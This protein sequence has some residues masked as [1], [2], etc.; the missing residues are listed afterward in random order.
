MWL[1]WVITILNALLSQKDFVNVYRV[2]I[3]VAQIGVLEVLAAFSLV[4]TLVKGSEYAAKYPT[5]RTSPTLVLVMVLYGLGFLS[6]V[7]GAFLNG[8]GPKDMLVG[9]REFTMYPIA[10]FIGYRLLA[11]PQSNLKFIKAML[12]GGVI[13]STM[14]VINFGSNA[15]TAGRREAFDVLR[16]VQYVSNYCAIA[17]LFLFF[18]TVAGL[19]PMRYWWAV[20]IGCFCFVGALSNFSRTIILTLIF[21]AI[22]M[23]A[24]LPRQKIGGIVLRS[25]V[26]APILFGALYL[27]IYLP[28]Q[29]KVRDI[30]ELIKQKL[31]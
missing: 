14:M 19:K 10:M 26:L 31:A 7:V 13:A 29:A 25:L 22:G 20:I 2:E 6:G 1:L 5:L 12:L 15:E 18:A 16:N 27:S 24:I 11:T 8:V 4:Y 28:S 17:A 9:I 30:F 23:V 21:G 3:G